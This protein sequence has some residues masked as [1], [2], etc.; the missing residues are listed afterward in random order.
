MSEPPA[1]PRVAHEPV[2]VLVPA[3]NQAAALAAAVPAWAAYLDTLRRPWSIVVVDDGSIDNTAEVTAELAGRHPTLTVLRHDT[4]RGVGAAIRTGLT[5]A[6]HPLLVITTLDH[7]YTPADLGALLE[8]I[9]EADLVVGYRAGRPVPLAARVPGVLWGLFNRIALGMPPERLPGWLGLRAHVYAWAVW[10]VFG[11]RITDVDSGLKLFRRSVFH[12]HLPIQSDGPFVHAEILAKANFLGGMM[13]ERP[14]G[15]TPGP[16]AAVPWPTEP[17]GRLWNEAFTVF[18]HP[19]FGPPPPPAPPPPPEAEAVSEPA[20][21]SHAPNP[22]G[23][24]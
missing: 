5:A 18:W 21:A 14:V 7:A 19:D 1:R 3:C 16:Y 10:G 12:E 22:E 2:C 23:P 4:R 6:G 17:P 24:S 20:A 8:R 15:R 13:D 11:V 9:D